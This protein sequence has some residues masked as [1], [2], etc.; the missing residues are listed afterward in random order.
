MNSSLTIV[1]HPKQ[2]AK[3]VADLDRARWHD[4]SLWFVRVKRD[5]QAQK[6]PEW[7]HLRETASKIK[8][9]TIANWAKYLEQFEERAT[10]LGA[11]V[12]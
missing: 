1:D 6:L 7:E 9:H 3:F 12:H 2:A 11:K 4:Q 8:A 5:M 10:A